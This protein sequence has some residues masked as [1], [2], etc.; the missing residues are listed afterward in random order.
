MVDLRDIPQH[1]SG[2]MPNEATPSIHA[3]P[4]IQ[5][6]HAVVAG[7]RV[8]VH[9]IVSALA[10]GASIPEVCAS[11]RVTEQQVRAALAYAA[12]SLEEERVVAVSR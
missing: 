3:Q 2:V 7:T 10:D 11:Y 6:G 1:P 9:V 5:G 12:A 8:P 4:D